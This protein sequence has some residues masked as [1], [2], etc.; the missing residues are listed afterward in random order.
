MGANSQFLLQKLGCDLYLY[1]TYMRG[2][3]VTFSPIFKS[4]F[5]MR[6]WSIIFG[7]F[8]GNTKEP[9]TALQHQFC[10]VSCEMHE[11]FQRMP[12]LYDIKLR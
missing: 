3:T 6:L 7:C 4:S 5:V 8:A 11:E 9:I 10:D 1:A 12:N 2:D